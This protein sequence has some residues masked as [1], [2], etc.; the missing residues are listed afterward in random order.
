MRTYEVYLT[1]GNTIEV[2]ATCANWDT[3]AGNIRFLNDD[4]Y[5]IALFI[6]KNICGFYEVE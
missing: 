6:L 4:R 3:D 1:T 5:V 2:K